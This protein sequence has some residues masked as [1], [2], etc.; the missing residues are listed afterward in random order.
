MHIYYNYIHWLLI[1]SI[2]FIDSYYWDVPQYGFLFSLESWV[3][4]RLWHSIQPLMFRS[5]WKAISPNCS[6]SCAL[7]P[8]ACLKSLS[9]NNWND[10]EACQYRS[11]WQSRHNLGISHT[12]LGWAIAFRVWTSKRFA[13][14][15]RTIHAITRLQPHILHHSAGW[16][17]IQLSLV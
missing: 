8:R 5:T 13:W 17:D 2:L 16:E 12:F 10:D 11:T 6:L 1:H 9:G 15:R 7:S 4:W 3:S 14:S